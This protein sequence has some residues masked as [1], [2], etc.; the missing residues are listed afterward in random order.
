M[1]VRSRHAGSDY[2]M[3]REATANFQLEGG[4]HASAPMPAPHRCASL[5]W[6]PGR[7]ATEYR[8]R[9]ARLGPIRSG[10]PRRQGDPRLNGKC[11]DVF[12]ENPHQWHQLVLWNAT[13]ARTKSGTI[14]QVPGY[15]ALG[16]AVADGCVGCGNAR[17]SSLQVGQTTQATAVA[18]DGSG[19]AISGASSTWSSSNTAESPPCRPQIGDSRCGRICVDHSDEQRQDRIAGSIGIVA[20]DGR[21]V[22]ADPPRLE[23]SGEGRCERRGHDV[24]SQG[25]HCTCGRPSWP[26]DGNECSAGEP[27]HGARR[28][29]RDPVRV[30]GGHNGAR[31]VNNVTVRKPRDHQVRTTGPERR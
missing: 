21:A 28:P 10:P 11:L 23:H 9:L 6:A 16:S 27:R 29:E 15:P 24:H 14:R 12:N 5:P 18:R 19:A 22:C 1:R 4:R 25:W 31:W 8:S 30:S 20:V 2:G 3:L 17:A 7:T 13:A 26:K